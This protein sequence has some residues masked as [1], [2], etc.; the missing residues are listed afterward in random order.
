MNIEIRTVAID[1]LYAHPGNPRVTLQPAKHKEYTAIK[2]S[3]DRFGLV[4]PIV[5]NERTGH[6][7]SGHQRVRVMRNNHVADV[8]VAV[9]NLDEHEEAAL[10]VAMNK[11]EGRWDDDKLASLIDEVGAQ[12][13]ID[14]STINIDIQTPPDEQRHLCDN[15]GTVWYE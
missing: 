1:T 10:L 15:C 14:L 9:V 6:I 8:D 2:T 7:V 11:I 12:I 13:D 3:L 4:E 5:W